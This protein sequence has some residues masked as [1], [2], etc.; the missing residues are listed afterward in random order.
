MSEMLEQN[1]NIINNNVLINQQNQIQLE[2]FRERLLDLENRAE[3]LQ[4]N[5]E[6]LINNNN[7]LKVTVGGLIG[8]ILYKII[9]R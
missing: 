5:N 2:T 3:R 1:Q 9:R 4:D 8:A 6:N 7:Y